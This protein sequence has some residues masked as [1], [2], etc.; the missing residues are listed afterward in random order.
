MPHSREIKTTPAP[1][2]FLTHARI[3]VTASQNRC[4]S[5]SAYCLARKARPCFV[6]Y[7]FAP[8]I[9][10]NPEVK[11]CRTG[12]TLCL[13]SSIFSRISVA[14]VLC[15]S[16]CADG[17]VQLS[18][19]DS[20]RKRPVLA[21]KLVFGGPF[22]RPGL[23]LLRLSHGYWLNIKSHAAQT[24]LAFVDF[25]SF[26]L[27]KNGVLRLPVFLYEYTEHD[28]RRM[29]L[30]SPQASAGQQTIAAMLQRT[31]SSLIVL[32]LGRGHTSLNKCTH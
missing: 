17:L 15:F 26:Y 12:G 18:A 9:C 31:R 2:F 28:C 24:A 1:Y 20:R 11:I 5:Y 16:S 7:V 10:P 27:K 21:A 29:S 22:L 13:A 25:A 3:N 23:Q 6:S 32:V 30:F 19:L 4:Y 14:F 8:P